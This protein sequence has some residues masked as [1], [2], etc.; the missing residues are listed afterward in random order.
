[1]KRKW[2][3]W[4]ILATLVLAIVVH[5]VT[6]VVLPYVIMNAY[7]A[8]HEINV[9]THTGRNT[10]ASRDVARPNADMYFSN[11]AYDLS[12][13]PILFTAP[14]PVDHYWSV[15][16]YANNS[17]NFFVI[18]DAQVKSN[19]VKILLIT[20]GMKYS[21]PDNAQVVTSPTIRGV[22]LVRQA[23]PDEDRLDEV[24]NLQK[25]SSVSFPETP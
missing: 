3:L 1:M 7:M 8:N 5:V 23:V 15:S 21:N 2:I 14:V 9:L 11:M 13:G 22:M 20:K 17:D 6:L 16:Y 24:A 18:N 19:P 12:K 25:Q 10:S 4:S